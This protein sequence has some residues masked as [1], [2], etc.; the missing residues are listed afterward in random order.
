MTHG[1]Q[2][3]IITAVTA[4]GVRCAVRRRRVAQRTRCVGISQVLSARGSVGRSV[5]TSVGM[6]AE[7]PTSVARLLV[8]Y[9][10]S[11]SRSHLLVAGGLPGAAMCTN[12]GTVAPAIAVGTAV[13]AFSVRFSLYLSL[14]SHWA[15]IIAVHVATVLACTTEVVPHRLHVR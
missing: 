10:P 6:V 5:T 4:T 14:H 1:I 15:I 11:F 3:P 2:T 7:P 9:R 8:E 12:V 13:V